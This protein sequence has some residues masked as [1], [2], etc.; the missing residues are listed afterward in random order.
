MAG[1]CAAAA[2]A[3]ANG[4]TPSSLH[5]APGQTGLKHTETPGGNA[6]AVNPLRF[7]P[8]LA[9]FT[10]LVFLVLLAILWKFW[11]RTA[12]GLDRREQGIADQ[13]SE[14]ERNNAGARQLLEQY[15]QKL[16]ASGE[17]VQRMIE[18]A[19]RDA[20]KAGHQIVEKA[21]ADAHAEHRRA[22][23]EIEQATANALKDL[24]AESAALAVELAGKIVAAKLDPKAHSQLIEQA[25]AGF[26][27]RQ[28]ETK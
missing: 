25:V 27:K 1:W 13:I 4:D 8:D 15:R 10:G 19:R 22:L 21:K 9:I 5:A 11:A 28:P 16:A 18:A 6:E 2:P 7:E 12:Q 23:G 20:E 17:E 3:A 24:A 14:A 26:S